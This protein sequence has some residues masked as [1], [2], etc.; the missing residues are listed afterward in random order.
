MTARYRVRLR[1]L[2]APDRSVGVAVFGLEEGYSIGWGGTAVVV[3]RTPLEARLTAGG[4]MSAVMASGMTTGAAVEVDLVLRSELLSDPTVRTWPCVV[5]GLQ[6]YEVDET[7]TACNV[8]IVDPIG[9]LA[10]RPVWGAY[11]AASAGEMIGGVLSLAAGGDGKPTLSP[12]LPRLPV[13]RIVEG[14][15]DRLK[16]LP[17]AIVPGRTLGDWLADFLALLGLRA[18]LLGL[19]NGTLAMY[20][21]DSEPRGNPLTMRVVSHEEVGSPDSGPVSGS[22]GP[23]LIRGHSGF[24]GTPLR[25]GILD[26]PSMGSPRPLVALGPVG[27]VVTGSELDVDEAAGR[28]YRS[29][30]GTYAEMLMLAAIS[31]QPRFRPGTLVRLSRP[32]HGLEDWQVLSAVHLVRDGIYD[33]DV[34]LI[35]GDIPWH[36]EL[37]LHRPPAFVT[38]V[39]DG[40]SDFD[41]HQP[42]PRDRLGRIKVV[43]P[44]TPTPVG[45][46]AVELSVADTDRDGRVTLADFD[47]RQL[48]AF[49]DDRSQ[50]EEGEAKYR[51][52]AYDDPFPGKSDDELTPEEQ[53]QRDELAARRQSAIR[54]MAYRQARDRDES[55][56]DRD[57]VLSARDELIS[58]ELSRRL[59][60]DEERA[61]IEE[62]WVQQQE[63]LARPEDEQDS[64]LPD[65]HDDPEQLALVEEY[66]ELFGE[67]EAGAEAEAARRDAEDMADFWP[68]R[69]PLSLIEPM[70]GAMHGFITAH[71]HGDICRVAVHDPFT[72]E[73]VGFQYRD[74]RRINADL[75]GAVAGLV[76]EH[77]YSDAWSGL[78]FRRASDLE[79][80]PFEPPPADPSADS[81]PSDAS[82]PPADPPPPEDTPPAAPSVASFPPDPPPAD[83]PPDGSP[84]GGGPPPDGPPSG[85]GGPPM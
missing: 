65:F 63:W 8:D 10:D 39:V 20:L 15:R 85:G 81:P 59:K 44:F 14:F 31:R 79:G 22:Y 25:G 72:A 56:A 75:S 66:G 73:I 61:A 34:N 60:V 1:N 38:G 2:G 62:Q 4:M 18:E 35:R 40:G 64:N 24:P 37:P 53:A 58:D 36:P 80:K 52:G 21:L 46:E 50:W 67:E 12:V 74:D 33:N 11:R 5:N 26:D 76:V 71:R 69:I 17:Y 28:I 49:A 54:Y 48:D 70:A 9:F 51:A 6:P 27:T 45:Q 78:V 42:V 23:I 83:P 84:F 55:D 3:A 29:V 77:N 43:F 57:G 32:T 47:Q 16:K 41:P 82:S 30:R 19:G 7:T 13:V 68:P